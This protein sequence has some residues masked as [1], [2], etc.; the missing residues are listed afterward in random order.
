AGTFYFTKVNKTFVDVDNNNKAKADIEELASRLIVQGT[1][2]NKFSP[3]GKITRAQFAAMLTRALGLEA[4]DKATPFKDTV[5]KWHEKEVQ[6]LYEAGIISGTSASRFS[7]N[8]SL[9]REQIVAMLYK[10]LSL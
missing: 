5:G 9:T 8:S 6:A 3:N 4:S 10:V 2:Q 7:P 1:G